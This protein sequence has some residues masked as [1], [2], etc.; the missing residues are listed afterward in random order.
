MISRPVSSPLH[1]PLIQLWDIFL[2]LFRKQKGKK[3]GPVFNIFV[4]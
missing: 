3:K 1:H 4:L 2:S